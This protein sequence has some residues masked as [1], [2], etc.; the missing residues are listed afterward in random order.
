MS[1]ENIVSNETQNGSQ[2]EEQNVV[3]LNE[4]FNE[5]IPMYYIDSGI[6]ISFGFVKHLKDLGFNNRKI[7]QALVAGNPHNIDYQTAQVLL[8]L[9]EENQ[10]GEVAFCIPPAVYKETMID[11]LRNDNIDKQYTRKFVTEN[12]FLTFPNESIKS[13]AKKSV[14]LQRK[15]MTVSSYGG[16]FGLGVDMKRRKV[17]DSGTRVWVDDNIE[18]RMILAQIAIIAKQGKQNITYIQ[19]GSNIDETRRKVQDLYDEERRIDVAG[20]LKN[21]DTKSDNP[22]NAT[23]VQINSMDFGTK[24]SIRGASKVENKGKKKV[25]KQLEEIFNEFF[26]GK[27]G[28]E[29]R[30]PLEL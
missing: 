7:K 30:T 23:F 16:L 2:N 27:G 18:D 20:S 12:C 24:V 19:C 10:R 22:T 25:A 15:L 9:Y 17:D 11:N 6:V 8:D 1:Q 13:F 14:A 28:L 3:L 4:K 29:V 26:N 21:A 5:E